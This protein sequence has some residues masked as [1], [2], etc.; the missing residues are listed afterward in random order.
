M[1]SVDGVTAHNKLKLWLYHLSL[2]FFFPDSWVI[3]ITSMTRYSFTMEKSLLDRSV[4][5]FHKRGRA[6]RSV[7]GPCGLESKAE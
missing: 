4:R 5:V 3:F 2:F 1:D 6:H 7:S